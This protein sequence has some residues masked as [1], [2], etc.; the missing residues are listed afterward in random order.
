MPRLI[1]MTHALDPGAG[2]PEGFVTRQLLEALATEAWPGGVSVITGGGIPEDRHGRPLSQ[3]PGWRFHTIQAPG[4]TAK[5]GLATRAANRI[6]HLY[7]GESAKISLWARSAA[8]ALDSELDSDP[9][10]IVYSRMLPFVS[11]RAAG[12]VRRKRQ[13]RWLASFNDPVPSDIWPAVYAA[14]AWS[15][16]LARCGL[17]RLLPWIGGYTFP[18]IRMRELQ[19]RAFPE[20]AA[21]PFRILPH[22]ARPRDPMPVHRGPVLEIA[23]AGNV[24]KQCVDTAFLG[25]LRR[26]TRE[27]PE[28]ARSTRFCYHL[29]IQLGKREERFRDTDAEI[30]VTYGLR[31]AELDREIANANVLLDLEEPIYAPL[32][33]T[34]L[35]NYMAFGRPVWAICA[36]GGT[37]W[38]L[39]LRAGGYVSEAGNEASILE[40]LVAIHSDWTAGV[41]R[42][43][44]GEVA[45]RFRP[46]T[47]VRALH[48]LCAEITGGPAT[49]PVAWP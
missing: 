1:V 12:L 2:G 18:S 36:R 20:M 29:W 44:P 8:R 41:S 15:C 13:F 23:L 10:A 4:W 49:N 5:K 31:G 9:Q 39:V 25:A 33:V 28:R 11:L 24:R 19:V 38:N 27:H 14:N 42:P 7:A 22:I 30:R 34:K 26:F 17:K 3:A 48:E 40:T 47:Q 45:E 32:L 46:A 35:A 6:S 21:K 37:A 43:V 16:R